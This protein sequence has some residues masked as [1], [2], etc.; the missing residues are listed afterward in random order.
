MGRCFV[1]CCVCF[2]RVDECCTDNAKESWRD[3]WEKWSTGTLNFSFTPSGPF[4][5]EKGCYGETPGSVGVN[6]LPYGWVTTD[7][8]S[9]HL[10]NTDQRRR[11]IFSPLGST[12]TS[13]LPPTYEAYRCSC[14]MAQHNQVLGSGISWFVSTCWNRSTTRGIKSDLSSIIPDSSLL[15]PCEMRLSNIPRYKFRPVTILFSISLT[16][17][18]LGYSWSF[19][20]VVR[21]EELRWWTCIPERN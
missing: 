5:L 4:G 8:L 3:D 12:S 15:P 2:V 19:S 20:I 1:V 7:G 21:V 13:S 17:S 6:G 9:H 10:R 11:H 18:K 14:Q 16:G